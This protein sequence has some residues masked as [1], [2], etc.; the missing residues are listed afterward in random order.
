MV[1]IKSTFFCFL[2]MN[3]FEI[4]SR[5]LTK[6]E[7]QPDPTDFK[8]KHEQGGEKSYLSGMIVHKNMRFRSSST[9]PINLW[10]INYD[11]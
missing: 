1:F 8:I 5:S 2:A 9:F 4:E 6:R 10:N 3:I 11:Y 7:T